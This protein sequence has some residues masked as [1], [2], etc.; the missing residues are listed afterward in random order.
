MTY[1][2]GDE[3]PLCAEGEKREKGLEGEEQSAAHD[4][5]LT[6]TLPHILHP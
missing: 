5:G 6:Q 2:S 3:K 4:S 1:R